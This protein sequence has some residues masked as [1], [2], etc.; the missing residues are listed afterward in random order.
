VARVADTL[1]VG[2]VSKAF[3]M[4]NQRGKTDC[5]FIKLKSR[6]EGHRATITE[7]FQV[8]KDVVLKHRKEEF[9]SQWISD[10]LKH[11][12]VWMKDRYKDCDFEH[13]GW[14]K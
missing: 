2:Q 10:K 6:T 7:D 8:M 14:I 9:L 13:E 4:V 12:Y 3:E 1:E 11:T 5:A